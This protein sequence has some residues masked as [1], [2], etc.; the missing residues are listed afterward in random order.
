MDERQPKTTSSLSEF[1]TRKLEN[2][3]EVFDHNAW[4][5]VEWTQD[6]EAGAQALIAKQFETQVDEAQR[7]TLEA[8]AAGYWDA[9]Y[10]KNANRFFKDRH[11]LRLE[12]PELFE[13]LN[14]SAEQKTRFVLWEI[15]CGA[16]N[17]VF[18]FL[19]EAAEADVMVY[20]SDYSSEAISVVKS[21]DLYD[22]SRCKAFVHD[23]TSPDL[24]AHIEPGTVDIITCIFVLS[25]IHPSTW[26][27]AVRNLHAMLKPGG[28]VLFRDYGRYDLA[29]LRFKKGRL[30][31][32]NFYMRGD[33]TRVY[34]FTNDELA[35]M[36]AQFEILQNGHDRR[37]LINRTRKLK[38]Y[39]SWVQAKL[40][41]PLDS[42][43]PAA[44]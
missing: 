43:A 23:I 32:D 39:R 33:G 26:D 4:D 19:Q 6:Q 27:R 7:E 5:N 37:L 21:N 13:Q 41:K 16:G 24:P 44:P 17:T 1:G 31:E 28:V 20:A 34:F 18:P 12:F 38:M 2:E 11:W 36:F 9:F 22:E 3:D 15:G 14:K 10:A 8:N 30:L 25:A 42:P 40:R 35:R 29:Q